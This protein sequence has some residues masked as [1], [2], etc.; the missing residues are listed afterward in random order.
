MSPRALIVEDDPQIVNLAADALAS[1]EHAYDTAGSQE[2]A[3]RR[4]SEKD[5]AYILLD[6]QIPA[7]SQNGIARI[8]NTENLLEKISQTHNGDTPPIIILSDY[9]VEG[10]DKTVDVMRLAMSL[11]KRGAVDILG[12]PFPTAGRTLD[13]VIKKVLAARGSVASH[14]QSPTKDVAGKPDR[15]R[16]AAGSTPDTSQWLSVTQ[17]AEALLRDL[18]ALDMAKARSRISTAAGRGEFRVEGSRRDRRID[19]DSFAAWRLKLRDRDLDAEDDDE[20][21]A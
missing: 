12:K 8:Q 6:I 13:R 2:E 9:C 4:L 7:R 16:Q 1:L 5:Y 17:A 21:E 3:L 15:D 14:A 18:P 20:P 19:P 11:G 10:L